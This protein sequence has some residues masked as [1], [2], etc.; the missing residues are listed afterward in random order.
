MPNHSYGWKRDLPDARD[1]KLSDH[2]ATLPLMSLPAKVDLRFGCGPIY[3]QGN[4][5]SCTANSIGGAVQFLQK[6]EA[7][8]DFIPS[9]LFIYYQERLDD[10]D[11]GFDAGS[12]IRESAKAVANYGAPPE[13]DWPYTITRFADK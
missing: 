11:V 6:K 5:G 1:F 2:E 8:P 4:L 3:D 12:S 10:G 7:I 13:T 9:R